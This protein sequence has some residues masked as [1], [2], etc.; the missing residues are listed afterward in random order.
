M[1]TILIFIYL[2]CDFNMMLCLTRTRIGVL[3]DANLNTRYLGVSGLAED[4]PPTL[5]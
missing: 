4:L 3:S 5:V 1:H 2:C